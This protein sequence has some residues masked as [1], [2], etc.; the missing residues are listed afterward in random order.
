MALDRVCSEHIAS[1]VDLKWT[2]TAS[3]ITG[4]ASLSGISLNP[5]MLPIV[6]LSPLQWGKSGILL[7]NRTL[8]MSILRSL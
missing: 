8:L 6:M 1:L 5:D 4:R 3:G 7:R 2:L